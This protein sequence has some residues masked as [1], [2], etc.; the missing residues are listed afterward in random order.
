MG[1]VGKHVCMVLTHASIGSANAGRTLLALK[2]RSA[3]LAA[4][5]LILTRILLIVGGVRVSQQT[6]HATQILQTHAPTRYAHA[7]QAPYVS[8][9]KIAV[10]G[11]A[12]T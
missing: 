8:K 4:D 2:E 9:G 10:L 5:A 11:V 7:G 12:Q 6:I 1:L 3:V